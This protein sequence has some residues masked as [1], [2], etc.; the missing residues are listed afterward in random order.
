MSCGDGE[1]CNFEPDKDCGG[2]D[3]GGVCQAKG[4]ICPDI[5]A[6]VCGCD[7]KTYS[8]NCVAHREG[9][10]V[11]S[12]GECGPDECTAAGGQIETSDGAS[13]PMCAADEE[14]WSIRGGREATLCCRAKPKA[15]K[16]CGG[17]AAL[18]CEKGQF[19][20]YEKSAGGQ[21]CDG[22]IADGAGVCQEQPQACTKEYKP[23]CGCDHKT[24]GNTCDA[25][26][27]GASILH[28]GMCTESDCK[29]VNGRVEYGTGPAPMCKSNESEF[30]S[31]GR[32]NG[33]IPIEG[34]LCCVPK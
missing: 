32:D 8:S 1:F 15:G 31:V 20:N 30:T 23:V 27:A 3:K 33:Q 9:V 28:D 6:P 18:M 22:S 25:H 13:T 17:F 34:A 26:S 11:K 24:H 4:D 2:T 29:A 10:S 16:T 12:D 7:N 14:S 19:C 21:G 5:Y